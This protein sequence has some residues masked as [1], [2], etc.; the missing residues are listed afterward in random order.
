MKLRFIF[1]ISIVMICTAYS[2]DVI[3]AKNDVQLDIDYAR[4]FG[5]D[6]SIF[7]EVYYSFRTN[8][9]SHKSELDKFVGALNITM[10]LIKAGVSLEKKEWTVPSVI[11]D[12]NE[13]SSGKTLVG[14]KTFFLN[15][16][17]YSLVVSASDFYNA[18]NKDSMIYPLRISLFPTDRDALSDPELCSSIKQIE[19]D[20]NNIFYKNT[21]EVVPSPSLLYGV[22]LP[23]LYYY[24]E[25]YNLLTGDRSTN[26]ILQ[27]TV[28]DAANR[29][30]INHEKARRRVNNSSVEIGTV[31][32]SALK[33]GTYTLKI[34]LIDTV[35]KTAVLSSKKFFVYKPGQVDSLVTLTTGGMVSSEYAL[36]NEEELDY[37]F[38]IIR[39]I[40]GDD[41][42]NQYKKLTDLDA[43]RKFMYEFWKRRD[44]DP[45]TSVN[46]FKVE[47]M[48]R[49][50][51]ANSNLK[52]SFMKGW[53][54]DR[55]R[56]Y[57]IY[58]S[59]DDIE[60][61][62]SS[63]DALPYEI[64]NYHSLQGGVIF[65][66]VDQA[67]QGDYRLVHSNHRNELQ[68]EAWYNK[69]QKTR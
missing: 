29:E 4:F 37:E 52:G 14:V 62:P 47:Y 56:V 60:R 61:Y 24:I 67:S 25:A 36:M 19:K 17:D 1:S 66:F 30:I 58:G 6:D 32:T 41:E 3:P 2:T 59:P 28:V 23:I 63:Y 42:K 11:T 33:G 35:K 39:Y 53:K 38:D 51:Y 45:M 31:N 44:Y 8:S 57:I 27:T 64:W 26:Y 18:T 5:N 49:V 20:E 43:K 10:D 7:L 12:T 69:V 34:A 48:R 21:L 40:V 16:G 55:G 9:I 22:G 46:E 50:D 68:D 65:I 13:I 15:P 54:S